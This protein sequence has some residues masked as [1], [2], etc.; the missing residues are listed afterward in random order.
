MMVLGYEALAIEDAA[1]DKQ[2]GLQSYICCTERH[3][4]VIL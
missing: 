1:K 4:E 3:A 2:D